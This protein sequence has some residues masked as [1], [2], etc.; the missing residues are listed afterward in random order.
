MR[1]FM[2]L[3]IILSPRKKKMLKIIQVFNSFF[4]LVIVHI[5]LPIIGA[6]I[7]LITTL[8]LLF[9]HIII[10]GMFIIVMYIM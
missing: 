8:D 10:I 5:I 9:H 2:E 3:I 1:I 7:P 6:I 4:M